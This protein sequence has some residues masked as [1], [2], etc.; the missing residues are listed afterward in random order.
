MT[1]EQIRHLRKSLG[2]SQ[3]KF[4]HLLS[5]SWTT[6]NRWEAGHSGPTGMAKR[7]LLL[8]EGR[9]RSANFRAALVDPRAQDPMFLLYSLLGQVYA[10]STLHQTGT[11]DKT[12]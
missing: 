7:I 3:E 11:G 8:L 10:N 6:V 4:A 5:V 9:M 1:P 12:K 2:F